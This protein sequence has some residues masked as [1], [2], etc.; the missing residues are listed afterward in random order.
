[1]ESP[2]MRRLTWSIH[3]HSESPMTLVLA[4]LP[5]TPRQSVTSCS[6][7]PA[8]HGST[9][10]AW[11]VSVPPGRRAA[12]R[13]EV[14]VH[15][16]DP[17]RATP[18]LSE[19]ERARYTAST[20]LVPLS[21]TIRAE[22]LRLV[23][24]RTEPKEIA[25]A[26][27]DELVSDRYRYAWPTGDLGAEAMLRDRSGDC[28]AYAFL[29]VAWCRAMGIPARTVFGT[30]A[31]GRLQAHAWAEFHVSGT[32]WLPVDPSF[33]WLTAHQRWPAKSREA[34]ESNFGD[35]PGERIVFSHDAEFPLPDGLDLPAA[36]EAAAGGRN[37]KSSWDGTMLMA[38]RRVQWGAETL[39]GN[40][41]YLQPAYPVYADGNADPRVTLGSWLVETPRT[42]LLAKLGY[43]L[44]ALAALLL[45]FLA[46]ESANPVTSVLVV[47]AVVLFEVWLI[48]S[49]RSLLIPA[50]TL[51]GLLGFMTQNLLT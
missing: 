15:Q 10:D 36:P 40:V 41:P 14:L 42:R 1:M 38:G 43:V 24:D 22:A 19:D 21:E 46:R 33:A 26:F 13:A 29:F 18:E 3:N 31:T 27:F 11:L 25:R 35:L 6:V 39:A 45:P 37:S 23:G 12:L 32:G 20:A 4:R 44:C 49:R 28:G 17:A 5:D 51:V 34:V 7:D 30:W 2:D 50:A 48:A 47:G 8:P 16:P 9:D